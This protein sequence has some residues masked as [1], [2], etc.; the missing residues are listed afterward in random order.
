MDFGARNFLET[1]R[2]PSLFQIS[3]SQYILVQAYDRPSVVHVQV[4]QYSLKVVDGSQTFF[5]SRTMIVEI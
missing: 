2:E 5:G 1:L 4:L 3:L